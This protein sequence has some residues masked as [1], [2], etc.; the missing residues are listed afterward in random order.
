MRGLLLSLGLDPDEELDRLIPR[1]EAARIHRI[2]TGTAEVEELTRSTA[3]GVLLIESRDVSHDL[4][5]LGLDVE[6]FL[7]RLGLDA[8]LRPAEVTDVAVHGELNDA[9][10]NYAKTHPVGKPMGPGG[11]TIAIGGC[12]SPTRIRPWS[13]GETAQRVPPRFR[14]ARDGFADPVPSIGSSNGNRS[15]A[16]RDGKPRRT[17]TLRAGS[18]GDGAG[19]A[20]ANNRNRTTCAPIPRLS[21]AHRANA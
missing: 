19:S 6:G 17:G 12:A 3:L 11:L 10:K 20:G 14:G 13:P 2:Q 21:P 8:T 16:G 5:G 18:G 7:A 15:G 1:F 4:R 9:L